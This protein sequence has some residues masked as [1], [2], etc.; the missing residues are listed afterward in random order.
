MFSLAQ[1]LLAQSPAKTAS[2]PRSKPAL[3]LRLN[4]SLR[5]NSQRLILRP[6]Q[7][8]DIPAILA[9]Y[10]AHLAPFE[11]L[12]PSVF[13]TCSHWEQVLSARL[14]DIQEQRSLKLFIF[15]RESPHSLIGAINF[16]NFI[17]GVFQSNYVPYNQR[18]GN[19]LKRLGFL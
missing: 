18:S 11:P 16:S 3:N 13:Y 9:Y 19:L 10:Q 5:L 2:Q 1:S 12:K 15:L 7:P 6:G 17:R 14:L 8:E 4:S